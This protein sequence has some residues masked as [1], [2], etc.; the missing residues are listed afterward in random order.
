MNIKPLRDEQ[1][2]RDALARVSVLVDLDPTADSPEGEELEVLGILVQAYE[3]KQAPLNPVAREGKS[4]RDVLL[5]RLILVKNAVKKVPG[6]QIRDV[7]PFIDGTVS[8]VKTKDMLRLPLAL[9]ASQVLND[10]TGVGGVL[11]GDWKIV[12]VLVFVNSD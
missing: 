2:Y 12:P 11:S 7:R 4:D 6:A 5:E 1:T 10:P 9:P 3:E 8:I